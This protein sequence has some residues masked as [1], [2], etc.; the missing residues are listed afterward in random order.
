[1][2]ELP[3]AIELGD[4]DTADCDFCIH[5]SLA[6][7]RIGLADSYNHAPAS[8]GDIQPGPGLWLKANSSND[9]AELDAVAILLAGGHLVV[10]DFPGWR[11]RGLT[12]QLH[13][14]GHNIRRKT[15][16]SAHPLNF[17]NLAGLH[18]EAV[19]PLDLN[20]NPCR[21]ILNE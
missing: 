4:A 3:L 18:P 16:G 21:V 12:H 2:N 10:G 5:E 8:G 13:G 9:A 20:K 6:G 15:A 17:K 14:L 19:V 1:L 11:Q 7:F